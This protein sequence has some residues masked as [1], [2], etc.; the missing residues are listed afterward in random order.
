MYLIYKCTLPLLIQHWANEG[1]SHQNI[2]TSIQVVIWADMEYDYT[3]HERRF[4]GEPS[5][6]SGNTT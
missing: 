3:K 1:F 5:Q 2:Q 6:Y 4:I